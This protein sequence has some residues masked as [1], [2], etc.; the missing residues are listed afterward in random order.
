MA[1]AY[2]PDPTAELHDL[3]NHRGELVPKYKVEVPANKNILPRII[4]FKGRW[5]KD[6]ATHNT[7]SGGYPVTAVGGTIMNVHKIIF[8]T[9]LDYA[10]PLDVSKKRWNSYDD[11]TKDLIRQGCDVDHIDEDRSN[12]HPS[13]LQL[14]TRRFNL[15]KRYA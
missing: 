1:T 5:D 12:F 7:D 14:V 10:C 2:V 15:A 4:S 3:K 6:L 13:N 9:L 8:N 11:Y